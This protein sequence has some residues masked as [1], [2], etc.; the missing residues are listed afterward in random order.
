MDVRSR[1]PL[2]REM[3]SHSGGLPTMLR[4]PDHRGISVQNAQVLLYRFYFR[5]LVKYYTRSVHHFLRSV[6][7]ILP[8]S[9]DRCT[10]FSQLTRSVHQILPST[11]ANS[12]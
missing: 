9:P 6:H 7:Q 2:Y 4:N 1:R 3:G 5:T 11:T 12:G 8:T 10:K